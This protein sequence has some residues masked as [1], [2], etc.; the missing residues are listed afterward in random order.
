MSN[1]SA[2]DE[3]WAVSHGAGENLRSLGYQGDIVV[4]ENGVDFPRGAAAPE[5]IGPVE[6]SIAKINDK[7]RYVLYFKHENSG[8]LTAVRD[9]LEDF[10]SDEENLPRACQ[11]QFDMRTDGHY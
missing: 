8:A 9:A 6:A 3:V 10:L 2:C 7:Y 5:L 4:M 11:V 1:I